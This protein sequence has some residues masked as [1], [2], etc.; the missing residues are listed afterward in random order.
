M[1]VSKGHK[2]AVACFVH[3]GTMPILDVSPLQVGKLYDVST[4]EIYLKATWADSRSQYLQLN[5]A[6]GIDVALLVIPNGVETSQ[7]TTLRQARALGV[8]IPEVTTAKRA[9]EWPNRNS[10]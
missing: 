4:S 2:I 1:P 5:K 8:L 7:F 10:N 9:L 6:I 3:D